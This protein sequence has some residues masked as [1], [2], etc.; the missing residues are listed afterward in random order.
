ME[1]SRRNWTQKYNVLVWLRI[2]S[3]QKNLFVKVLIQKTML[4]IY[5]SQAKS[6]Y[7][8]FFFWSS[9]RYYF[10]ELPKI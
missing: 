8:W 4:L 3:F 5:I 6:A 1:E 9:K 10:M 7:Q 2:A